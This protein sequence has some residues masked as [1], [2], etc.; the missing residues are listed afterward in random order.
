MH[1]HIHSP[2]GEVKYWLEPEIELAK[3]H[4]CLAKTF[5]QLK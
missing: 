5:H 1:V 4:Q 2:E 3:I